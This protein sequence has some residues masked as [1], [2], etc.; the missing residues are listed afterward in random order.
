MESAGM[1]SD[2]VSGN[3][4][5]ARVSPAGGVAADPAFARNRRFY[6]P[7]WAA[8]RLVP[9]ESFN[10]WPLVRDVLPPEGVP[11]LEIGPGLRPRLPL[12]GSDFL[13]ASPAAVAVLRAAG[14]RAVQGSAAA[15]PYRAGGF[16][17]IA[18]LDVIEHVTDDAAAFAELARVAAPGAALLLS[19]PL[20]PTRWSRFDDAVGHCRRYRIDALGAVLAQHGWEVEAS[21]GF[22]LRPRW[23]ALVALGMWVLAHQPRRAMWWYNRILPGTLRRQPPLAPVP[24]LAVP[25]RRTDEVLLL[26]RMSVKPDR[27]HAPLVKN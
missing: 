14:G 5:A 13:D 6:D 17:L 4:T 7:L 10:T 3:E 1:E 11:R 22:G 2:N 26:A 16:G 9:P 12:A 18:A 15:L 21:A 24:G 25:G 19:V 20:D 8:A 27:T 23:P